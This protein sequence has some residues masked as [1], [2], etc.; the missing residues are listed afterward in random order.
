MRILSR[1]ALWVAL[2]AGGAFALT[3]GGEFAYGQSLHEI[4]KRDEAVR[5]AWQ[6]T[7]FTMRRA[8]FVTGKPEGFG[9]YTPRSPAPFKAGEQL[10]VYA[11]PL[12]YGWKSVEGDQ[13]EFGFTVDFVLKTTGGKIIGGQDKFADLVFKS[14]TQNREIFLKLDLDLTGASPG[15][16][17][18]DLRVHDSEADKTAMI[19]LPFTQE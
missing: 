13:Y 5:Q 18:L 14:R 1:D 15:N 4:E 19:E 17:L 2:L 12:A 10:V 8:L 6:K 11:E 3:V 9:M 16:Y 7:P